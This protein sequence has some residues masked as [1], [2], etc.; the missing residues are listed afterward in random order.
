MSFRVAVA[1]VKFGAQNR[2]GG[3]F[4]HGNDPFLARLILGGGIRD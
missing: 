3:T 2:R 4:D 1:G